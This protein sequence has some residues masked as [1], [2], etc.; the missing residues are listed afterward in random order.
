MEAGGR[1]TGDREA[2]R[3]GGKPLV[4]SRGRGRARGRWGAATAPSCCAA[5]AAT[6]FRWGSTAPL[7][8]GSRSPSAEPIG[9]VVA[10]Q[11]LQP[12]AQPDRAPGRRRRSRRAARSSSSRPRRRRCRACVSSRSCARPACRTRG[13]SRCHRRAASWRASS[14]PIRASASSA[15]SAAPRSAGACARSSRPARCALEHGGV[16]PVIVAADADLDQT[17]P[18]LAKGGFYHAG[19]VCV[20]VQRV[21]AHRVDR[22]ELAAALGRARRQARG[23]RSDAAGDRGRSADPPDGGRARRTTGSRRRS[24]GGGT[25]LCGGQPL[26]AT[27]YAP[28]V[29]LDP[30]AGL[31]RVD[32]RGVRPGGLRLRLRR[33]RRGDRARQR[34]ALGVPGGRVHPRPRHRDARLRRLDA[35]AVMLNDHTA[36]R[37]DWMP[38]AGLRES[39]LGVGGIPTPSTTCRSRSCSWGRCHD[40][41]PGGAR[42]GLGG[43]GGQMTSRRPDLS[44]A[45]GRSP[46]PR[47]RPEAGV[48]SRCSGGRPPG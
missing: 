8:G 21:F 1:G 47:S 33:P 25:L 29:L 41:A 32:A 16:A 46:P 13:A 15:S 12:P 26:S 24:H 22:R 36:F 20:S 42:H 40:E 34:A 6:S 37:V 48:S 35:S 28:T 4:D 5:R 9:V 44:L 30:P 3:E 27:C 7:A 10:V 31:P 39:G 38:F 43:K 14:S 45:A 19:Q 18:A 2:A 23:R 17:V 11:R